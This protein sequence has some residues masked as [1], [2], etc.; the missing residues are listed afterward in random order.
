MAPYVPPAG[1]HMF[2]GRAWPG[3]RSLRSY[4]TANSNFGA[5]CAFG[6]IE[7]V[8]MMETVG[9]APFA[10]IGFVAAGQINRIEPVILPDGGRDQANFELMCRLVC[11]G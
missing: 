7:Q 3:A 5:L 2:W 4:L 11:H 10:G 9:V 8:G 6:Q 1:Q